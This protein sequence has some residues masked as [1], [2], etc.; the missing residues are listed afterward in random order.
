MKKFIKENSFIFILL[1]I[2][3]SGSYFS[4]WNSYIIPYPEKV[5]KTGIKLLKNGVLIQHILISLSRIFFGFF[6]TTIT[7]VPLAVFWNVSQNIQLF[8]KYF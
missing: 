2:W 1:A 3:I 8:Q 5:L 7:A 4:L 6:L